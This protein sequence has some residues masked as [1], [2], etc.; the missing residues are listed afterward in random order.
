MVK[1]FC[2]F[3]WPC[4]F[5]HIRVVDDIQILTSPLIKHS[6]YIRTPDVQAAVT[7]GYD[8]INQMVLIFIYT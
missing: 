1:H 3:N 8:S 5:Q 2:H 4:Y 7:A 6:F